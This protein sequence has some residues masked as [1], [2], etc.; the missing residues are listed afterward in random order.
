MNTAHAHLVLNHFPLIGIIFAVGIGAYAVLR[1][2]QPIL[3]VA[4]WLLIVSGVMALPTFLT[5]ESAEDVVEAFNADHD[6]LEA[7]ED[8]GK[9][10]AILT[11]ILGGLALIGLVVYRRRDLG[12][13]YALLVL[14]AAVVAGGFLVNAANI[15]GKIMHP[16]IRSSTALTPGN[17][18]S[19]DDDD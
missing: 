2:K 9:L 3:R 11:G 6:F 15:G 17:Y 8:A 1:S 18:S 19:E 12:R 5:G 10:A 13:P 7:H 14:A 16:E 4:F